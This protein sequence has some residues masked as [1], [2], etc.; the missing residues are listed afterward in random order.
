MQ[1]IVN[2]IAIASGVVSLAVVGSGLY[3]YVQR[4]QLID[5]AKSKITEAVMGSFGSPSIPSVGGDA[6]PLGTND[7]APAPDAPQASAA[8][9]AGFGLPQ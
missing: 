6:L 9:S 4:D 1:K 7:L 3:V 5:S 2:L 8:P